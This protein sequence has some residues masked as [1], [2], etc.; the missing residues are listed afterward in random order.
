MLFS[1]LRLCCSWVGVVGVSFSLLVIV[2]V[3]MVSDVRGKLIRAGVVPDARPSLQRA[4]EVVDELAELDRLRDE[5]AELR[6][7]VDELTAST[8][9]AYNEARK[10]KS[11][12]DSEKC[13]AD[14]CACTDAAVKSCSV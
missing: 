9:F 11:I 10:W 14:M 8:E 3:M 13:R 1:A 7:R 2:V 5:N 4:D 12:A 6:C